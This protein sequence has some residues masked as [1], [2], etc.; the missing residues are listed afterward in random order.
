VRRK[1]YENKFHFEE[2]EKKDK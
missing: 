1:R 2:I